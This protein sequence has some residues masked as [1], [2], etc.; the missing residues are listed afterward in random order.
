[1]TR[2]R[3][4]VCGFRLSPIPT[5][6]S[7]STPARFLLRDKGNQREKESMR[8]D[9]DELVKFRHRR[10]NHQTA[11]ITTRQLPSGLVVPAQ[12]VILPSG[13]E[14]VTVR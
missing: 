2:K 7:L 4:R 13:E 5:E 9:A 8:M 10:T 11:W 6:W 3:S 14:Q 12:H 1:M